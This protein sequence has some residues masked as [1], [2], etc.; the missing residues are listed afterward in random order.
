MPDIRYWFVDENGLRAISLV[1]TGADSATVGN[2][3][4]ELANQMKRLPAIA[5]VVADASLDRPELRIL[6]RI[7]PGRSLGVS[8]ES[9]SE[10]DPGRHHRRRRPGAGQVRHRRP[11][12]PV[13]VQL[14]DDARSDSQK[15]EQMRV[16]MGRGGDMPLSLIADIELGQGPTSI[17]RYDRERQAAVA[18]DL[19][20]NSALG[21]AMKGYSTLPVMKSLPKA[22]AS[23]SPATPKA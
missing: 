22:S 18:S 14:T 4:N 12:I 20:G 17:R 2:V 5:N 15:L 19:I 11:A 13:R 16:P 21:D 6:P 7:G 10:T 23:S 9:L 3:A 8:T 1:V